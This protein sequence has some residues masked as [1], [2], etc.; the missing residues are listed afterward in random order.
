[1]YSKITKPS[2]FITSTGRTG[3][4]F[5]AKN[6]SLM[7]K[8]AAAYHEPGSP[9]I[10]RPK[11]FIKEVRD[12]GFY[13]MTAGQFSPKHCMFKL[14]RKYIVGELDS[15]K[16][17]D[18][19]LAMRKDFVDSL[20]K[21]IYVESSGHIYGILGIIDKVFEN[22]KFIHIVRDP[23]KWV[24]SALNTFEYYLYGPFDEKLLKLSP[25]AMDF[26][27]DNWAKKWKSMSKFEK[28][29]WF[30][31]KLN[32]HV[33]NTMEGKNNF[34]VYRFEDVFDREDTSTL[35]DM[36]KFATNFDLNTYDYVLKPDLLNRKIHSR[37]EGTFP[38]FK[39]WDK[40]MFDQLK[41]HCGRWMNRFD[42][43]L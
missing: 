26:S 14:S 13:N 24:T 32:D 43:Q 3:T 41:R 2:V 35:E 29:C 28:Y 8:D 5:L 18:Y 15:E 1:M 12:F 21:D 16:T 23:K 40:R 38:A 9:W 19:V 10:T 11:D 25:T 31:N 27:D 22:A 36:L 42:Y 39:D 20:P 7:V 6:I 37:S 33:I 34:R 30:Y 4:Q 17:A